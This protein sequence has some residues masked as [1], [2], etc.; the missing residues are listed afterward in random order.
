MRIKNLLMLAA[1]LTMSGVTMAQTTITAGKVKFVPGG[2]AELKYSYTS[3][4]AM[5]GFQMVVSL[6]DG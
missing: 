1:F 6:P 4:E 2:D 3:A 5:G